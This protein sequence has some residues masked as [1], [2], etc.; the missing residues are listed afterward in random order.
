MIIK[1]PGAEFFYEDVCYKIGD[2]IVGTD[3]SEYQGLLGSIIEIRDGEDKE[4]ENETPDIY[5]S[6][7]APVLPYDIAELEKRF[8][9]LYQCKKTIEDI[10][11][12]EVIMAPEMIEPIEQADKKLTKLN[13]YLVI[14]DW[15]MDGE[16]GHSVIP[17]TDYH[18]AK[19]MLC[20][21]LAEE[22]DTGCIPR[23]N[24][25]EN[26]KVESG[27][28][29]YECWLDGEYCESHYKIALAQETLLM[30][31]TTV[32]IIGRSY[33]DQCRMED[34]ASQIEQQDEISS[35]TDEQ[36]YRLCADPEIPERI[37]KALDKNDSYWEHYWDSMSEVA[38]DLIHKYLKENEEAKKNDI[39]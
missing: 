36:C 1:Q 5:C 13:I 26:F 25:K 3:A 27:S 7:D 17:C 19:C 11:L 10:I 31:P 8:S 14:E 34:F 33:M 28:Y 37:Q 39:L 23:W 21:K 9:E 12:D 35:L 2:R 24:D 15:A 32:G 30:S 18:T 38:R 20:E 22:Q 16:S 29:F 4:T 6:F